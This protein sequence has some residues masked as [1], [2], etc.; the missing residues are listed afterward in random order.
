MTIS[1]GYPV[2]VRAPSVPFKAEKRHNPRLLGWGLVFFAFL[3]EQLDFLRLLIWRNAGFGSLSTISQFLVNVE[4]RFDPT[5]V[6]LAAGADVVVHPSSATGAPPA[7]GSVAQYR[8]L[9]VSGEITP[10]TVANALLP[11]I[12]TGKHSTAWVEVHPE[13]VLKAARESTLRYSKGKPLGPLDGIPVAIKDE[14]DVQGHATRIGSAIVPVIEKTVDS[15]C[16]E[17]LRESGAIVMGK[18]TMVEFGIDTSG[19]NPAFGTPLNPYNTQYYTGGSSSGG[20]YSVSTGL[21]PIALGSDAGGS[22]RIP[23]S[24]CSITG[25]KPTHGRLSFMPGINHVSC[26]VN[27]PIAADVGSLSAFY[28]VIS[29]PHPTS[30]FP[31]NLRRDSARPRLIGI[32]EA[33]FQLATPAIQ[34]LCRGIIERLVTSKGFKVVPIEIPFIREGQIATGVTVLADAATVIPKH[35]G[36]SA[37]S[38]I[39]LALGRTTPAT[40]LILAQKLRHLLMQHF[41][42]LWSEHPGMVIVTPTTACAGWPIRSPAEL[43]YGLSD[44]DRTNDCMEYTWLANFCGVP[45]ISVPAGYIVPE[46]RANAGE[47]ADKDTEGMIPVG[48]MATGDWA[49]EETLL[50]FAEDVEDVCRGDRC[51]PPTWVDVIGLARKNME[52][53]SS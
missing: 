2:P 9:Y 21:V 16:V 46:G 20:A 51:R 10:T 3:I 22:I 26:N 4:P 14:F 12:T 6:P 24:F 1:L 41:A 8:A 17:K 11:L 49:C 40:D 5:V 48:I 53:E 43:K 23:A 42:W 18:V 34:K 28:S 7:S 45:S 37:T 52:K 30:S 32:P 36:M 39:L 15:W 50:R 44:G 13:L 19:C 47:V 29:Q 25:L 38:R 33:W 31:L 27:G 35:S